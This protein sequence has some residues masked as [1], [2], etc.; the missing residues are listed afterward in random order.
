VNTASATRDPRPFVPHEGDAVLLDAVWAESA[1]R[2]CA[3]ATVH[4]GTPLCDDA[5][6]GA[7]GWPAWLVIELFAQV[8]AASAGLR[9]YRPG[10]RPRLG[11]LL[12]VRQF[13]SRLERLPAGATLE[14]TVDESS[15]DEDGMGVSDGV[16]AIAGDPVASATL[17][18]CLPAD[19]DAYLQGIEP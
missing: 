16:L 13:S 19:V 10:A 14:L 12:G 15:R 8:V 17:S 4:P 11:L 2:T 7:G 3:T 6:E 9:E 18:V 1:T 5:G